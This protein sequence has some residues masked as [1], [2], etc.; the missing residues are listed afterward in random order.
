M[1]GSDLNIHK[2]FPWDI[3][4]VYNKTLSTAFFLFI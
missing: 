3:I 1:L 4:T 2:T